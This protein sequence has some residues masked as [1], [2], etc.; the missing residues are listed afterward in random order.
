MKN[1]IKDEIEEFVNK[2]AEQF[3]LERIILF[4][5]HASNRPTTD[6]DV[7][8]LVIMDFEGRPHQKA[9]EIRKHIK[10]PFSLDL[11][12]RWP[13][14]IAFRLSQGDFFFN[15]IMRDGKVL[16]ES[17]DYGVGKKS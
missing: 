14:E 6:S 15:E 5:S 8:L 10:R 11:L 17:T 16:Y 1:N 7:D 4:G 13:D 9:F 3:K 12:V 2:I